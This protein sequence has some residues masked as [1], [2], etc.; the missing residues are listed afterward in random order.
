MIESSYEREFKAIAQEYERSG[1]NVSDFL[2]KDIVSI[3][4]SGNKIIGRNTVEGVHLSAKELDNGVEVWLD[5][6]DG[7][8]VNNPIHLCTDT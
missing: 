8:L 4:V 1:G 7:I 3:I 5:I 6:D 2:R